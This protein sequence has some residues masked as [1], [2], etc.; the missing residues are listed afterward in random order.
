M[1]AIYFVAFS[2]A[3]FTLGISGIA[4]SRHFLIMMLSMEAIFLAS[5]LLAVTLFYYSI[6]GNIVLML[7]AIWSVAAA[8]AMAIVVFYRYLSRW[9]AGLDITGLSK[10]RH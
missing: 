7:L 8:E 2:V 4:A 9:E 10:L 1:I 5:T 3:I 6:V